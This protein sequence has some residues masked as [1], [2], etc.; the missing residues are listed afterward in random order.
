MN[1]L[2]QTLVALTILACLI[3]VAWAALRPGLRRGGA[4]QAATH[5]DLV[6][7]D[8]D[9]V[10]LVS[11]VRVLSVDLVN[12]R[13]TA[14]CARSGVQRVFKLSKIVKATDAHTGARVQ[15][16][17]WLAQHEGAGTP[18]GPEGQAGAVQARRW[19]AS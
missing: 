18:A 10:L 19:A 11:L 3:G 13:M 8:E 12:K 4:D 2:T 1:T 17:R 14:W 16:A 15:L 5:W 6:Y 9:G 7:V